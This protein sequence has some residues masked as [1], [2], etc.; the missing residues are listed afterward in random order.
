M[1]SM[2]SLVQSVAV[3]QGSTVLYPLRNK[4]VIVYDEDDAQNKLQG[5]TKP[6]VALIYNGMRSSG[7][8][9]GLSARVGMSASLVISLVIVADKE[10]VV[11]TDQK[12]PVIDLLDAVRG[13]IMATRSPTGHFWRFLVEAQASVK[14]GSTFWVQRWSTPIQLPPTQST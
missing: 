12:F 11:R 1:Q 3:H 8:E 14:G 5:V 13:M 4:A 7:Q 6:G 10:V 9:P 2:Y